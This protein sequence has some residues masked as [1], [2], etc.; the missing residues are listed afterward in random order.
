MRQS[1]EKYAIMHGALHD[2]AMGTL[3][4]IS[5]D[6]PKFVV[7][8]RYKLRHTLQDPQSLRD[9]DQMFDL[10]EIKHSRRQSILPPNLNSINRLQRVRSL[11]HV[12]RIGIGTMS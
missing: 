6:R 10:E 3:A 8:N 11:G 12:T 4:Q 7:A 2:R 5:S 9:E 1:S